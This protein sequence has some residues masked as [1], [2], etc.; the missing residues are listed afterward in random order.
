MTSQKLEE[1]HK[2][3]FIAFK[4]QVLEDYKIA[5][6]SRQCS[7]L[8]RREV[9][10]GKGKF[11]IFGDGKELPQ[12]AMNRFFKNGDFRSGYYRDQTLLFAQGLLT[13]E[14]VFAAYMQI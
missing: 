1:D 9:F 13:V 2:I 3:N 4:K 8:G 11:G 10:S 6:L 12:L 7:L 14:N 5:V